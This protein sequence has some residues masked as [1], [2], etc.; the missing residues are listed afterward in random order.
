MKR[1]FSSP[2]TLEYHQ[3]KLTVAFVH[4][5]LG[6]G[7]AERLVVDAASGLRDRGH[8]I[9]FWTTF[10]DS[11][12]C[13]D[14]LKGPEAHPVHVHGNWFPRSIFGRCIALCAYI[15]TFLCTLSLIFHFILPRYSSQKP[16]IVF[17]DQVSIVVPLLRLFKY[18]V[19]FYC[20]FPDKLLSPGAGKQLSQRTGLSIQNINSKSNSF[21]SRFVLTPLSHLYRLPL[22]LA[23]ELSTGCA[24]T[25]VVNSVYTRNVFQAAFRFLARRELFPEVVYPAVR[26]CSFFLENQGHEMISLGD[27][28]EFDHVVLSINRFERKKNI[29]LA[30]EAF[31]SLKNRCT[32]EF[33]SKC[34]LVLAGGYDSRLSENIEVVN[35]LKTMAIELSLE[36]QVFFYPS[37]S[38]AEQLSLLR[39]ARDGG[40]LVYTPANEHFGIVPI[41][42]MAARV[43]VI[44]VNSGGP[45]E[46]VVHQVTGFLVENSPDEFAS[47]VYRVL[48]DQSLGKRLGKYGRDRAV[49]KFG[50]DAFSKKLEEI[51]LTTVLGRV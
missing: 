34:A 1:F 50:L 19:L 25:I 2:S 10:F 7:G 30:L 49:S 40:C 9:A 13:F 41:E 36:K 22:N 5:D 20:H 29:K 4:P 43:P 28:E 51:T 44:A 15:R 26:L 45:T 24:N 47:S 35:E 6:L 37:F 48:S 39:K 21:C 32:P 38:R 14:E 12:R 42:A 17:V 16:H 8:R 46:S 27:L 31:Q 23:E 3:S 11:S 33:F 18:K